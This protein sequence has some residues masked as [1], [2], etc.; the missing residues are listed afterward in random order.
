M[1]TEFLVAQEL[2]RGTHVTFKALRSL[3]VFGFAPV[4]LHTLI[5]RY[6]RTED[7]RQVSEFIDTGTKAESVRQFKTRVP[8]RVAY[9]EAASRQIPAHIHKPTR[10]NG[11]SAK[12]TMEALLADSVEK[13]HL[14]QQHPQPLQLPKTWL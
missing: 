1:Q 11:P 12:Q 13:R 7:I 6:D 5:Y 4:D 14:L 8:N 10:R 9:R 3:G 2:M